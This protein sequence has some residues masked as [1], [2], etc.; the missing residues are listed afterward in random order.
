MGAAA[1]LRWRYLL[2]CISALC[3]ISIW[4]RP[5]SFNG[6][7]ARL[8]F[9]TIAQLRYCTGT[10]TIPKSAFLLAVLAPCAPSHSPTPCHYW[11]PNTRYISLGYIGPLLLQ[12]TPFPDVFF[13][14]LGVNATV[15]IVAK[16]CAES[17][18]APEKNWLPYSGLACVFGSRSTT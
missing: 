12:C 2:C 14:A 17:R 7:A 13:V 4:Y 3:L 15:T 6:L 8:V 9:V 5:F 10:F 18:N 11:L 1:C 16:G